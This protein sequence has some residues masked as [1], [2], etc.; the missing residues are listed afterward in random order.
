MKDNY[1][2]CI[3]VV[4][5]GLLILI[6]FSGCNKQLFDFNYTFDKAICY[7]GG[8][9]FELSIDKWNDYDGEQIQIISG[10]KTYLVSTNNCYL[11]D[12]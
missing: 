6:L 8:E 10:N 1:K 2:I 4:V 9:R 12:E 11:I 5:L 7:Y 3:L